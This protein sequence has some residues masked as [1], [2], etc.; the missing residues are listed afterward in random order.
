MTMNAEK[1]LTVAEVKLVTERMGDDILKLLRAYQQLTGLVPSAIDLEFC[2]ST[3]IGGER[4]VE[5]TNV[6]VT[7]EL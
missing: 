4:R 1:G 2:E 5:L 3:P 7:V 6:Q